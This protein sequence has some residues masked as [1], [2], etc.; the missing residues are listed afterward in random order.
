MP[1]FAPRAAAPAMLLL[2]FLLL[3]SGCGCRCC[4][5]G[6]AL[7]PSHDTD[8]SRLA[9]W[10]HGSF[11][12]AAQAAAD[13]DYLDIRLRMVPIWE[14]RSDALWMY[15]EQA[16]AEDAD[17][18]YRQRIYRLTRD[19][20]GACRSEVYALPESE[21]FIGAWRDTRLFGALSSADLLRR[22][23]CASILRFVD[24][25]FTGGTVGAGCSSSLHG[26][27]YATSEVLLT[28][29]RMESWDRGFDADGEQIWGAEKGPYVFDRIAD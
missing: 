17:A 2:F 26:A 25:S 14:W 13:P 29:D 7:G 16:V 20:D 23:G 21:K 8:L 27:A 18:P 3:A 4:S 15:V 28:A 12:S 5:E 6:V 19:P 11:S 1:R 9:D 22:E 24:G 10:L